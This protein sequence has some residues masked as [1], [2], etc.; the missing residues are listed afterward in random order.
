MHVRLLTAV[1]VMTVTTASQAQ[2]PAPPSLP[3][4]NELAKKLVRVIEAKDLTAYASILSDDLHVYE[5]GKE[6]AD[7]KTKWLAT[8]GKKLATEGVSF[9]VGPGF[10]ST[11]RLM[12]IEYFNSTASWSGTVPEHCCW[13]HDAVAYD[14]ADGKVTTIRRLRGGD[15][16]LDDR[17]GPSK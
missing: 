8:Y 17:G 4:Q 1:V 15:M 11:G 10:S 12:F 5:D 9:K 6:I 14:V 16:K 2:V 13:S 7:R 3:G